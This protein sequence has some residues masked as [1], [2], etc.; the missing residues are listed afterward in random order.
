MTLYEHTY[1]RLK[2]L[3]HGFQLRVDY[4]N[5]VDE[6]LPRPGDDPDREAV[7]VM[8]LHKFLRLMQVY[9]SKGR[10]PKIPA[11]QKLPLLP[12]SWA[13]REP[14]GGEYGT[15]ASPRSQ[16][17]QYEPDQRSTDTPGLRDEPDR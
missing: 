16:V 4:T 6:M 15:I 8:E 14:R 12:A 11:S 1:N 10:K 2:R 5:Y 3:L 13:R 9:R 7:I 17:G